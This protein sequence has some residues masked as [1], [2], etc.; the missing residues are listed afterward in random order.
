MENR[1]IKL[2]IRESNTA[3]MRILQIFSR[4]NYFIKS[5]SMSSDNKL[6][7]VLLEF[8]ADKLIYKTVVTQLKKLIDLLE[9][10]HDK[11]EYEEQEIIKVENLF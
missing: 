2:K 4:R 10:E 9:I 1:K 8:P 7:E 11:I 3:M 5:M 6:I